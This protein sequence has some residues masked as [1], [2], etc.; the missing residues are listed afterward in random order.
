MNIIINKRLIGNE[1]K[2]V[3]EVLDTEFC[4]SSG[5]TMM[6]RFEDKFSKRF[7]S[8]FGISFVNGTATMHAALEAMGVGVGDEVIVTPLTM[9]ATT[10][11]VLQAN[12]TPVFADVNPYTFQ[13]DPASI[14]EC[15]TP[16]TKVIITVALYGLSPDMDPIIELAKQHDIKVIEDNAECFLAVYKDRL[17]GTLGDCASYSFQSSKHLTCGEGGMILTDDLQLAE[18]IRKVQSLGYAGVSAS[19]GKITKIDIQDPNYVR[20]VTMGWNYR[21]PELCCAVALAQTEN[22]DELVQRRIDVASIFQNMTQEFHDWFTPQ[23]VGKEYTNSYW[24]WVVR[25]KTDKVS[26]HEFRDH[27]IQNG[28]DG[29]YAAWKLTY[30]EPMFENM[31]LLGREKFISQDNRQKYKVGL[32]PNA[33]EIQPELFQFKTNYWDIEQAYRQAEIL[34]DTLIHFKD[35]KNI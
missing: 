11:A 16:K 14:K 9:S 2:Y 33:E 6:Q 13:I 23:H 24:T 34:R 10:F 1:S 26:W 19:K 8:K 7:D 5:S 20:H 17:V 22:I 18:K 27:F 15:I 28:G 32:C 25:L 4:S 35:S 3:Q 30:L 29:V 12:A 31:T 21:M